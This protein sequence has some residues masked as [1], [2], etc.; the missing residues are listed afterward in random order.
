MQR[1]IL[2]ALALAVSPGPAITQGV[3][4]PPGAE[5]GSGTTD[6]ARARDALEQGKAL[7]L[8]D[9]LKIVQN[10]VDAR[11]IEVEFEEEGDH[12]VY[13]FELITPDGRLLEAKADPVTGRILEMGE[14]SDDD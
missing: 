12:Y 10:Q 8:V 1:P 14:D 9:I 11:I 7:P 3:A 6:V 2:L 4:P 5:P 13:E